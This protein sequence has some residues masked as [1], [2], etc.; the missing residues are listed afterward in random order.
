VILVGRPSEA[1][2]DEVLASAQTAQFTYD[3]VGG[4]REGATPAGF[5][6]QR[7]TNVYGSGSEAFERGKAGLRNWSAH[8][9]AG[10]K[11]HPAGA[12][13]E[14]GR[15]VVG[16]LAA[17]PVTVLFPCR[18]VYVIDE[19]RRFGWAYGTLPGHPESGE[20]Q[21]LVEWHDDDTVSFSI[22]VF[23]K[24]DDLLTRLAGPVA[25]MAQTRASKRY[26]TG[27]R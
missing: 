16:T 4:T 20:E 8:K 5:H 13:L 14:P 22:N 24:P 9:A 3:D 21:F 7:Y 2:V 18:I 23:S 26:L 25:R 15:V 17:G 10:V 6:H 12:Q 27:I 11:V 1:K 19:S